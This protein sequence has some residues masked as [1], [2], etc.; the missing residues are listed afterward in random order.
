[1]LPSVTARR[2][3][4]IVLFGLLG[5]LWG[6]SFLL[7]KI[8]LDGLTPAQVGLSRL[9]LGAVTLTAVMVVTRRPWPRGRRMFGHLA[10]V[11]VLLFVL[12]V[13][14]Y[15][16]AGQFLPSSLSAVLNATTP[17]MTLVVSG[18]ALRRE[19]LTA[20]KVAGVLLGAAGITGV[21]APWQNPASPGG[22]A[23][24]AGEPLFWVA[25]TACLAA[26]LCYG[27][28]YVWMRRFLLP[29]AATATYDPVSLTAT[30]LLIATALTAAVAPWSGVFASAPELSL[31]VVV[32][33]LVLGVLCTGLGYLW[34]TTITARWGAVRASQVTYLTPLVGIALGAAIL[35]EPITWNQLAGTAAVLCGIALTRPAGTARKN[36]AKTGRA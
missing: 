33:M 15:S 31:P 25:V 10:V 4:T 23:T 32:S 20:R 12:P 1:M 13:A 14:L 36:Q 34:N 6:G 21:L 24:A 22:L 5:L 8:S 27:G 18:I 30:Q 19:R 2:T 3:P 11:A 7:I 17:L 26:T 35:A 16:W 29:A 9:A 28:A